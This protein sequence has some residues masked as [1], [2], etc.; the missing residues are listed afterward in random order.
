MLVQL[1]KMLEGYRRF[2]TNYFASN[3]VLFQSLMHKQSPKTLLIGCCDSRVDPAII[4]DC[5]PGDLFVIRNV[6]NLVGPYHPDGGLHGVSAAMEYAVQA[7]NVENIIVLGHAH[8]GGIKALME[9]SCASFEFIGP[10]VEIAN[11][12]KRKTLKHFGQLPFEEQC[13]ACEFASILTSL[14]NIITYPWVKERLVSGKI[15]L[16]GWYFDFVTGE[17]MGYVPEKMKFEPLIKDK[18]EE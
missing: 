9:G 4:T 6:A 15:S 18:D 8:C 11:D 12:A 1:D 7:L 16:T 10:W 17:L 5:E 2:K 13:R 3:P 14:E